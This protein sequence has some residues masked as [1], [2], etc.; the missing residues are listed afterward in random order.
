MTPTGLTAVDPNSPEDEPEA[1]GPYP[2]TRFVEGLA[3]NARFLVPQ[4]RNGLLVHTGKWAGWSEGQPMPNSDGCVHSWPQ[5][6]QSIAETLGR[7]GV[8]IRPNTDG[9]LPYP[10][11][12]QGLASVFLVGEAHGALPMSST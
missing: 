9:A 7:L 8:G 1:F 3:G 12:P 5:C 10:Y 2:V 11:R 4:Q 6:V